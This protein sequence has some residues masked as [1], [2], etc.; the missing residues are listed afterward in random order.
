[1][2]LVSVGVLL[3][4]EVSGH[5]LHH[6]PGHLQFGGPDLDV[7]TECRKV[8]LADLIRPQQ[9]VHHHDFALAEVLDAQSRQSGLVAQREVDDGDPVRRGKRLGKQHIGF[10][11]FAIRFQKVAAVVEQWVDLG[12]GNELQDR[13]LVAAFLRQGGDVLFG[14]HHGLAA[15]CFVGLGDV[16]VLHHLIAFTAD[17]LVLDPAIVCCVHLM[18]LQV[19]V[20]GG[21]V[22]LHGHVDQTERDRT[23]PDGTHETSMP[24][25][26]G[27]G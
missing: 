18:K 20:L 22:D 5:R 11:G 1:M 10:R 21:A 24:K 14:D 16:A 12:G 13:D 15:V 9:C 27:P 3:G 26:G 8:R 19:V 25:R 23:L 17:T 7:S 2:F 6:L 4:V